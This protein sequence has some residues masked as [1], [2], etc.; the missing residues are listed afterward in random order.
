VIRFG[1]GQ[2][3]F[4]GCPSPPFLIVKTPLPPTSA[5]ALTRNLSA[6]R[7]R[8]CVEILFR[9]GVFVSEY[10]RLTHKA[11]FLT[12]RNWPARL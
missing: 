5:D 3:A 2:L 1:I 4:S 6:L 7:T 8:L 10:S 11:Y 9:Y 12:F